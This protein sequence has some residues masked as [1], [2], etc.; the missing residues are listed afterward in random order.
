MGADKSIR[1]TKLLDPSKTGSSPAGFLGS[2]HEV[3]LAEI[4]LVNGNW[5]IF[6]RLCINN[7]DNDRQ[8]AHARIL[9]ENGTEIDAVYISLEEEETC[10]F[11]LHGLAKIEVPGATFASIG[12]EPSAV[13]R[14]VGATWRGS[15]SNASL[16][17]ISVGPVI[18]G[19]VAHVKA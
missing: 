3:V 8:K 9:S 5:A 4:H 18:G 17:A 19:E 15:A 11:N 6:G 12:P 1:S 13:L 14:V 7:D 10:C 16:L 2:F